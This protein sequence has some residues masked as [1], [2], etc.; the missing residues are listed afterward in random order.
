MASSLRLG[1]VH[2]MWAYHHTTYVSGHSSLVIPFPRSSSTLLKDCTYVT[3]CFFFIINSWVFFSR[4][5]LTYQSGGDAMRFSAENMLLSRKYAFSSEQSTEC[6]SHLSGVQ[7]AF[8]AVE[9][10]ERNDCITFVVLDDEHHYGFFRALPS[11][12]GFLV[13]AL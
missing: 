4:I 1:F 5:L 13:G 10:L 6:C 9:V 12:L 8:W 2:K 3:K 11:S 7:A